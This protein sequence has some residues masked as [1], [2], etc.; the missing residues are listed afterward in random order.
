MAQVDQIEFQLAKTK[1][2]EGSAFPLPVYLRL[3]SS[4]A[5]ATPT[6]IHYRIDCKSSGTELSDWTSVSAASSFT[7]AVTGTHNAIQNEGR[8][9]EVKQLTVMT[10][11][12]LA[13]QHRRAVQW[14]VENLY[15][16]P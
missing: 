2:N 8:D 4:G 13:T 15:G 11:Q 5:A 16:S 12:G 6:T 14:R 7:I 10:D 1:W 9:Y 3:R